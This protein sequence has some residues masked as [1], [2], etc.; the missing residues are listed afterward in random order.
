SGAAGGS[1]EPPGK[2]AKSSKADALPVDAWDCP[3]CTK[4]MTGRIFQ[5]Q[6]GHHL[7]EDCLDELKARSGPCPT[8]RQ[9][10]PPTV[11]RNFGMEQ[12]A[13]HFSFA[14][15]QACGFRGKPDALQTHKS[16]CALR[17]VKCPVEECE[18]WCF[19][20]PAPAP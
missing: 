3:I 14:C 18:H 2:A 17:L 4:A 8:C 11:V 15:P 16:E 6:L 20:S 10:F 19:E 12:L 7:C 9:L 13:G 1:D 5:C